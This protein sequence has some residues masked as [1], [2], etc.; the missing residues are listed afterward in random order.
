MTLPFLPTISTVRVFI[1]T[2]PSRMHP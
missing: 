2:T 1:R